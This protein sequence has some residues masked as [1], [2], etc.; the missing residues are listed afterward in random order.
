MKTPNA[1]RPVVHSA[2]EAWFFLR[3]LRTQFVA[4]GCRQSAAALTYTTLFAIV[5]ILTVAYSVLAMVPALREKGDAMQEWLLGVIAPSAGE[6]VQHYI[7]EFARQTSN[8]TMVGGVFLLITSVLL[9]RNIETTLNRIWRVARPRQGLLALLTYWAVL[10]LGPLTLAV[11]LGA[12]SYIASVSLFTDTVAMVGGMSIWLKLL[13]F[14]MSTVMLTLLYVL[15]PN[16]HVPLKQGVL[17]GV[18]AAV[19]FELA[20]TAFAKFIKMAPTYEIIYGAFAA[21]P[22]FLL[23]I[24]VSWIIVLA[25]A[26]LVRTAVVFAEYRGQVPKMQALLR[27]LHVLWLCQ[28]RG[29]VLQPAQLR[30][31]LQSAHVN[32][33]DEYRD[34]LVELQLVQRADDG[35]YVLTRDLRNITVAELMGMTPWPL[36]TLLQV[37]PH[38]QYNQAWE[39]ALAH[40]CQLAQQGLHDTLGM[41]VEALFVNSEQ[42]QR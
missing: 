2:R 31:T 19:L 1:L 11:G 36:A 40:H 29:V 22:L 3:L 7:S 17:G 13:P 33:W 38:E 23:W 12:S 41:S 20:K 35:T 6:Q 10:T 30:H 9:L 16:C 32:Q 39:S 27:A 37:N 26:E 42:R 24:Y 21:V 28:Q 18:V 34:L 25:G 14:I 4:D 15:V 5:P 8:L